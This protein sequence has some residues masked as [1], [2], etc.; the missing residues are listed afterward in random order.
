MQ[1]AIYGAGSLGTVLGAFLTKNGVVCQ[2][3]RKYGVPTPINDRIVEIIRQEQAGKLP[4]TRENLRL[5]RNP[6]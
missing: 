1:Y 6:A 2:W 5:F 4:L 3:G